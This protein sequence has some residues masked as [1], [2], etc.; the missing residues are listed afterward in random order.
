DIAQHSGGRTFRVD[1]LAVLVAADAVL[2]A[3][4]GLDEVANLKHREK[5]SNEIIATHRRLTANASNLAMLV[6]TRPG[7]TSSALTSSPEFPTLHLRRLSQGLRLQ[8]LQQWAAVTG[9][10]REAEAKLQQTFME[11]QHVPHIRELASYPMQ[12]AILLHLLHRRQLFPQQRTELY[13]EYLKTFL[14][15]EQTEDKEPLLAQDRKVIEDIHAYL[16]WLLQARAEEGIS[17]GTIDREELRQVLHERL[18]GREDGQKLAE[19][20]FSAV[21]TRVLCLIERDPGTF[22]FEVQSLREYFAALFIF[23][24]APPRGKGNSRDDCLNAL[25]ERPYWANVCRFFVGMFSGVEVRGIRQN[26][27]QADRRAQGHPMFRSLGALFLDD[28]T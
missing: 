13:R 18:E 22:Q 17:S 10:S 24:N 26:L 11:N 15:R 4:D 7:P 25:L 5:V 28:R 3:L 21:T 27:E 12:L 14:D 8:Y 2:I 23:D 19:R 9:L 16:G 6:A 20:L 1:D